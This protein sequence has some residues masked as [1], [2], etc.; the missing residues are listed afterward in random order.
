MCSLFFPTISRHEVDK[1]TSTIQQ[2]TVTISECKAVIAQ[3]ERQTDMHSAHEQ[4]A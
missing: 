1:P 3:T 4:V 2:V